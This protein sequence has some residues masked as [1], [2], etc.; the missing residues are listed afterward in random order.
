MLSNW[1]I[2]LISLAYMGLLFLVAYW[3]DRRPENRPRWRPIIYGLGFAVHTTTWGMYGTIGQTAQTGWI[4]GPTYI[5]GIFIMLFM[6]GLLAKMLA[7][8]QKQNITSIADFISAR[9]GKSQSL[10]ILV[11][12]VAI[13]GVTPYI[14]LQLK[15]LTASFNVL[16][17]TPE[18]WDVALFAALMMALFSILFG[19]RRIVSSERHEGMM[20][21]VAFGTVVKLTAF[22]A[23][24]IF[25]TFGLFD[26]FGHIINE[27]AAQGIYDHLQ[28][29]D[30]AQYSFITSIFLGMLAIFCLP[31]SFQVM[32]VENSVTAD[33]KQA[34]WV[35]SA[36]LILMGIFIWPIASGGLLLLPE[37]SNPEMFILNIPL[38][39]GHPELAL[40]IYIGGLSA[41]TSMVI[42]S[43]I[44]L[45]TMVCNSVVMPFLLHFH[46]VTRNRHR[47]FTATVRLIRRLS[48]VGIL[49]L[50]YGYYRVLSGY[51]ELASFGLLSMAL[52]GQ[53]APP[54]IGG[55]YWKQGHRRGVMIGLVAGFSVC[56]YTLLIP[57]LIRSG[58]LASSLLEQG[59]FG[60][61]W[62]RPE[63][64]GFDF[65]D[66]IGHGLFWSLL[67]NTGCY[68]FFSRRA[69]PNLL[70]HIQA[71]VFTDHDKEPG[72]EEYGP[73]Q[74][75]VVNGDLQKLAERFIGEEATEEAFRKFAHAKDLSLPPSG[76]A[77]DETIVFTER[78]LAGAIGSASARAVLKMALEGRDMVLGDF[79]SIVDEASSVFKYNRDL[80]QSSMDNV[81]PGISVVDQNLRLVA[82][83]KSYEVM[84]DYPEAF[85]YEGR[86]VSDLLHYHAD[87]G[88][89]EN[90]DTEIQKRLTYMEQGSAYSFQRHRKDGTVIEMRGKPMPG[91]GF[92]TSYTD[93]TEFKNAE[94]ALKDA[95]ETLEQRVA[96]RTVE[97]SKATQQAEEANKSKT[98]FLAAVS[99]DVLQPLNAARVFTSALDQQKFDHKTNDLVDHL[100]SALNNVEEILN[101]V[102]DISK[103][104]AG[105]IKPER[106]SF[107]LQEL[108]DNLTTEFTPLFAEKGLTLKTRPSGLVVHSDRQFLRR[109][110]QNYLSNA[111]K[112]TRTGRILM[113]CRRAGEGQLRIEV[114]DS[115]PGIP[116]SHHEEIFGE[117]KRLD[118]RNLDNPKGLG[119]GLAIVRRMGRLLDHD[120]GVRSTPDRGS[121]FSVTVPLG[122]ENEILRKKVL[123][124]KPGNFAEA[125]IICLDNDTSILM[126]MDALLGGWGCRVR[127]CGT[128][129]EFRQEI[130]KK[131]PQVILADYHLDGA[132]TGLEIVASLASATPT[133]IISADQTEQVKKDA[134]AQDCY[135]LPKPLKAAA[136]RA[137]LGKII[138]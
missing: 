36:F 22:L 129:Q 66:R 89:L 84:L 14:A 106:T 81:S 68:V 134:R 115:G 6:G 121:I 67:A 87:R 77:T 50:A 108:F 109:I 20:L 122:E 105:A 26:G 137:L 130:N 107:A 46:T 23:I 27:A 79:V 94:A 112:Y 58:L 128:E 42:V 90:A 96:E 136:L 45:S 40:F 98:R 91:G 15:A 16:T 114:R 97:L 62:L 63:A 21:A 51:T 65:M 55:L 80:L 101:E 37:G 18:S 88:E 38:S 74:T 82:W 72:K 31:R 53:F 57:E 48:I 56:L 126:A 24:G 110:L 103:L 73:F 123:T 92:V 19:T 78:L 52:L 13:L 12:L 41:A 117:F 4:T 95:N 120:V 135:Y 125:D 43:T 11:T 61:Y 118:F 10:A 69:R 49:L 64:I 131:I 104:E 86:H 3:G 85:L 17:D 127:N 25:V 99:H 32:V 9:Y 47:D 111:L 76:K 30:T 124:Y 7:V 113:G 1:S 35:F 119:L 75:L 133:I 100:D 29:A 39:T 33:L 132:R 70:E 54:L 34:R 44:A 59:L 2:I 93:I 83:N 102:L 60:Q 28:S 138:V 71:A 116:E 5:G 8:G